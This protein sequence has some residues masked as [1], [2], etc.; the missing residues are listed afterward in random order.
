V[1]RRPH[2]GVTMPRLHLAA[3]P[4]QP[5]TIDAEAELL[6]QARAQGLRVFFN[7]AA[8]RAGQPHIELKDNR[9]ALLQAFRSPAAALRWLRPERRADGGGQ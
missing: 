6:A 1:A 4:T 8:R 5:G 2:G 3:I 9:N 7:R